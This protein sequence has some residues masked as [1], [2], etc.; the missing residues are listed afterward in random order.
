[1]KIK[2]AISVLSKHARWR[3]GEE[4]QMTDP[5]KLTEALAIVLKLLR[6]A[7]KKYRKLKNGK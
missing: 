7:M 3:K 5:H 1:M 4:G 6:L 2:K